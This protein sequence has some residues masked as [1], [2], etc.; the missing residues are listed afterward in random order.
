MIAKIILVIVVFVVVA[1]LLFTFSGPVLLSFSTGP[2]G[3]DTDFVVLNP[4]RDRAPERSAEDFLEH[5]KTGQCDKVIG[6]IP[7]GEEYHKHV[8]NRERQVT[9]VSWRLRKAVAEGGRVSLLYRYR[10][11]NRP[12]EDR[13][14]IWVEKMDGN[15]K[16]IDYK[17]GY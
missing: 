13:L 11:E 8:C 2:M 6:K 17:R 16:V 15:W 9:L 5:L 14:F 3:G 7:G 1:S 10:C 12:D 4:F